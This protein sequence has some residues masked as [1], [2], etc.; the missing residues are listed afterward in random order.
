MQALFRRY[1]VLCGSDACVARRPELP[2][3]TLSA[4]E[5]TDNDC[6][7]AKEVWIRVTDDQDRAT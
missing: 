7:E 1:P 6:F 5:M 3:G 4:E 2:D